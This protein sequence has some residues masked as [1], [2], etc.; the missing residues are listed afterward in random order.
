MEMLF[1][2]DHMQYDSLMSKSNS[3]DATT[4]T[5][6][7]ETMSSCNDSATVPYIFYRVNLNFESLTPADSFA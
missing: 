7:T 3:N 6:T 1:C 5:T 4:T 2:H